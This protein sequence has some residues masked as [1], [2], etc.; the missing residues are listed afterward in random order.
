MSQTY[1][2]ICSRCGRIAFEPAEDDAQWT[3]AA[4]AETSHQA[5]HDI[6]R[7]DELP[8]TPI[9]GIDYTDTELTDIRRN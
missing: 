5:N 7:I 3:A 9:R 1:D 4:H 6:M 8:L 2:V